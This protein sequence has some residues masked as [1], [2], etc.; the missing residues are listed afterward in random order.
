M[1]FIL[2]LLIA[3][4]VIAFIKYAC[5]LLLALARLVAKTLKRFLPSRRT[6]RVRRRKAMPIKVMPIGNQDWEAISRETRRSL[7]KS[8]P[9][10]SRETVLLSDHDLGIA[11]E[12]KEQELQRL[13]ADF[14]R[15]GRCDDS[16]NR[17][18]R[19]AARQPSDGTRVVQT[20]RFMH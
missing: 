14:E 16:W 5:I 9:R 17:P 8:G 7:L 10:A 11:I 20:S 1:Y 3:I 4:A 6:K 2:G 12:L 19:P 15:M 18:V 13:K